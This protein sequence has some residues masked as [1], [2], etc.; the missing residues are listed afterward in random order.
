[1]VKQGK[2]ILTPT[3]GLP[4]WRAEYTIL[5]SSQLIQTATDPRLAYPGSDGGE[6]CGNN[7]HLFS[8]SWHFHIRCPNQSLWPDELQ[9]HL[10]N[11][12]GHNISKNV[13]ETKYNRAS[14]LKWSPNLLLFKGTERY[15]TGISSRGM[16]IWLQHSS[17]HPTPRH[18]GNA[19][20][21][22]D[23]LPPR[24]CVWPTRALWRRPGHWALLGQGFP[25]CEGQNQPHESAVRIQCI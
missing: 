15:V 20:P 13:Y 21:E 4:Q 2:A 19:K 11:F 3:L 18:T 16:F 14:F 1:M 10:S 5:P 7:Y 23:G 8:L 22:P 12:P 24:G 17:A 6:L 25:L 9:S